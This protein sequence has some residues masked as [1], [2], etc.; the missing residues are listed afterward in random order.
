MGLMKRSRS[1]AASLLI[2]IFYDFAIKI[3]ERTA[4]VDIIRLKTRKNP[5]RRLLYETVTYT[6]S[7]SYNSDTEKLLIITDII[8]YSQSM[9]NIR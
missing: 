8:L 5:K 7:D 2:N 9:N 3:L 1:Y 4:D 6:K